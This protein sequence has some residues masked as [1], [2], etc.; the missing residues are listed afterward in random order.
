[1][2]HLNNSSKIGNTIENTK[3]PEDPEKL[4]EVCREFESLFLD[5]MLK[6]M[7]KTV[8][9]GGLV[10][11]SFAREMYESMQDEEIAK[12]MAKGG[13]IGLAQ[14]LYNQLSRTTRNPVK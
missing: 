14:E 12:D 8:P 9:D 10:E 4:M 13:G 6:Q 1:M 3:T 11:K 7:R 5:M 2:L